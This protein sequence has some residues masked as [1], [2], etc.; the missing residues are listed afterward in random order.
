MKATRDA[1]A[2][3]EPIYGSVLLLGPKNKS[4]NRVSRVGLGSTQCSGVE[5]LTI[6]LVFGG[7]CPPALSSSLSS[8]PGA[9]LICLGHCRPILSSSY[10]W[11]IAGLHRKI[12]LANKYMD[13]VF[14]CC[15]EGQTDSLFCCVLCTRWGLGSRYGMESSCYCL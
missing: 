8:S 15:A 7:S 4:D 11:S 2:R 1:S 9:L 3:K 14:S 6:G 13:W 5:C 12:L 10:C